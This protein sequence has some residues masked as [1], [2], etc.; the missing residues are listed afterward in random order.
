MAP[1]QQRVIDEKTELD[2][3]REKLLAF[4]NTDLFRGLDQA[5]KDRLRTQH[6]VMGVYSE[7]LHQ[8]IAA[9][10]AEAMKD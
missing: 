2:D 7:I 6:G 1:H 10:P 5:E 4:F 8:R 9:F 3:K